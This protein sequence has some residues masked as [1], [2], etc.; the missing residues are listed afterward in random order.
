MVLPAPVVPT[1]ASGLAGR[2]VEV[3]AGQHRHALDVLE[4]HP[5]EAHVAAHVVERGRAW[6]A[7]GRWA[8]SSS[9][10]ESFSSAA[11]ADWKVL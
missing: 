6:P 4:P 1:S 8:R 7:P 9:T 2:D 10:P 5:V 11:L 3:E